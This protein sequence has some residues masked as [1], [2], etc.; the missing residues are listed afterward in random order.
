MCDRK[1]KS[2]SLNHVQGLI[3]CWLG[4]TSSHITQKCLVFIHMH[5][6]YDLVWYIIELFH[7]FIGVRS[8]KRESLMLNCES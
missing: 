3:I 7:I 8:D 1:M 4:N 5:I 2:F 6:Y